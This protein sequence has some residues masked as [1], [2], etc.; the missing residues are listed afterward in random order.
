MYVKLSEGFGHRPCT[1]TPKPSPLLFQVQLVYRC[2][3]TI[4]LALSEIPVLA[5]GLGR[6]S[7]MVK[8][9]RFGLTISKAALD[10][11]RMSAKRSSR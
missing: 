7:L 3:R 2:E 1:G 9:H 6:A 8:A 4:V 5:L 10:A 11:V